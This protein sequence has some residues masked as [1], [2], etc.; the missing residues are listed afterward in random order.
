VTLGFGCMHVHLAHEFYIAE[1]CLRIRM[2]IGSPAGPP[3]HNILKVTADYG[4]VFKWFS[5]TLP[6]SL[7]HDHQ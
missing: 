6:L 3:S 2:L 4:V 7:S 5:L 1:V